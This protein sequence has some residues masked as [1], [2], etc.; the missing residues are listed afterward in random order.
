MPQN[1]LVI[2]YYFPPMGLS[3]VQRTSKFVKYLPDYGWNP[4]VLTSSPESYYAFDNTLEGELINRG[5]EIRRTSPKKIQKSKSLKIQKF[6]RYLF[7]KIGRAF[8]QT[9]YL[10]DSK[11]KWKK[12]ALKLGE[13]IIKNNKIDVIYAT[14]PPFT[15]FIISMELSNKF[16]I[17]YIIDY[18]DIWIDNPFH[19][20]ATPIHKKYC[21][22][23]EKEILTH[24]EKAIVTTR[25]TKEL[26][27]RR[28]KFLKHE[29]I[30]ILP[31]GFDPEDFNN[32]D[33]YLPPANKFVICH[34]GV[35]QDNRNPKYFF[36]AL[37]N[38]IKKN[39]IIKNQI[40]ARFVGL[41][42]PEHLKL[43]KKYR[44]QDYVTSTGYVT[45]SEAVKNLQQSH[46]L[47]LCQSDNVRSPGKLFEY[48]GARKPILICA[49]DGI[50]RKIA[51]SSKA[52][53]A[54]EPDDPQAIEAAI[55]SFFNM[56]QNNALPTI[57]KE[58]AEQYNR[59]YLT[60]QL[61]RELSYAI[62]I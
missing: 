53:I 51:A 23:L 3:G 54:T 28:Y 1:V 10:P 36:L 50:I 56:W 45:H 24:S 6:P 21:I 8:F 44:L 9:I 32:T 5:I 57:N 46:V 35:F 30:T 37:A 34:S 27:L 7:Q 4:I 12:S 22:N 15:D 11:I 55:K 31:H 52:A 17:P 2:A 60:E 13:D 25:Y 29:D 18:R 59:K 20:F 47:W 58:F 48:F 38:L 26:L 39:N 14:A 61:A 62:R 41:M 43:I 40:E 16:D 49:P 19:F 33:G 42:R